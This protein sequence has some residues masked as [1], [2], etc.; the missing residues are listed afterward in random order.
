MS[1]APDFYSAHSFLGIVDQKLGRWEMAEEQYRRAR[2]LNPKAVAPL[3]NL[4][5]LFLQES[6]L[7]EESAEAAKQLIERAIRTLQEAIQLDSG[8]RTTYFFLG[9][10]EYKTGAFDTAVGHFL[11][12]S[13]IE[14]E[15]L[16][17]RLMLA[18][19]D[20]KQGNWEGALDFIDS[21]RADH[22]ESPNRNRVDSLRAQVLTSLEAPRQ[23]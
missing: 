23:R 9:V 20:I 10:A 19:I 15:E 18:N 3:V 22:P 11:Q 17:V 16:P 12:A 5:S 4:G 6:E 2:E 21:W 14:S 7:P 8:Y 13:E 1:I